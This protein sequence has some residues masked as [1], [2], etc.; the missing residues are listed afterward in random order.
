MFG[1]IIKFGVRAGAVALLVSAIIAA[2]AVTFP[3]PDYSTFSYAIGKGYAIM[4]HWIPA[5]PALWQLLITS[6]NLYLALLSVEFIV[7]GASAFI[8]TIFK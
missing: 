4:T 8:L 7:S 1:D 3:S 6:L 5:F 2:F